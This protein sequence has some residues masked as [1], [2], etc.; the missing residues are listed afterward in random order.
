MSQGLILSVLRLQEAW[1]L[2][3]Y[4][5]QAV[6][7]FLLVGG[8]HICKTT[9]EMCIRYCYLGTSE[10]SQSRGLGGRGLSR[11]APIGSCSVT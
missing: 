11:E 2:C 5:H 8:L 3:A 4:G 9:Q 1:G 6:N 10:R 7:I